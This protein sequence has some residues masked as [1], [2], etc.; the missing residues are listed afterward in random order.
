M[1]THSTDDEG[2]SI[3]HTHSTDDEGGSTSCIHAHSAN[4]EGGSQQP[5]RAS[6]CR[7]M[8]IQ[9]ALLLGTDHPQAA[10]INAVTA[11]WK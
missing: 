7:I 4:D 9:G 8:G 5:C 6:L 10:V 11:C 1:H 3:M 2:G